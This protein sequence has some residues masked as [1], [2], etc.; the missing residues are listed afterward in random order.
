MQN[1][2]VSKNVLSLQNHCNTDKKG[3]GIDT[4]V[5]VDELDDEELDYEDDLSIT[6][7]IYP[8]PEDEEPDQP[9]PGPSGV[10][11]N[12]M[13]NEQQSLLEDL[14]HG[15][16]ERIMNNPIMQKMMQK[17][18]DE[19]MKN[20]RNTQGK[21]KGGVVKSS[22]NLVNKCSGHPTVK[23]PS[24][25]TIYA[26]ALQKKVLS[27][28]QFIGNAIEQGQPVIRE[29][30]QMNGASN[31]QN[32]NECVQRNE[33]FSGNENHTIT[34]FE[35]LGLVTNG[36]DNQMIDDSIRQFVEAVRLE[37][38]PG[39][40]ATV[41]KR[42][43]NGNNPELDIAR[44]RAE[45]ALIEAE[46]FKAAVEQPQAGNQAFLNIGAG[47]SD[48]DFFHLTCHIDPT[49][50][51]KIEQG[52]FVELEKLLPKDKLGRN[53]EESRLEW[54]QRDGG[55]FLVPAQ[56]DNKISGFR[57]WE[58]AFRAYATIYCGANPQRAKEIWQYIT[59]INTAASSYLWENVY[60]YDITF[61]H[62]MAF[63]PQRS[64]AVTYNQMWNLS[65]KD[66]LPRNSRGGAFTQQHTGAGHVTG[67]SNNYPSSSSSGSNPMQVRRNK[68]DYCWNFNKG[69]PCKFGSRCKFVE[70][71]K[72]CDSPA[73]GV[74]VCPKLQRKDGGGGGNNNN[75]NNN[76]S[77][78][79]RGASNNNH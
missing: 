6:E 7:E 9:V 17:F 66:P 53:N 50:I 26:P 52:E 29:A 3:D 55:T 51:H 34:G 20:M 21:G 43:S 19:R 62:L 22:K 68:S 37:S 46:K 16:E 5:D 1:K 67:R 25:T 8:L 35:N 30:M 44:N 75:N 60:S 39:D 70:R 74:H 64:W 59:V 71:C 24:D 48:D 61:R 76:N 31:C 2:I 79:S 10:N 63:N 49:L 41:E 78:N 36:N 65:M 56:R 12:K 42:K 72:Y 14:T 54:V 18:F 57:R 33:G 47:F 40:Q 23:S 11:Q 28:V 58:Q 73:H 32:R 38:H 27:P 15:A 69:I 45:H 77:G 13:D 4:T